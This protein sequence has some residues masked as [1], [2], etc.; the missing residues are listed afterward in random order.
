MFKDGGN[1][2]VLTFKMHGREG[3][4]LEIAQTLEGIVKKLK[5]V[6]GCTGAEIYRDFSEES[7]FFL[8]EEWQ[9]RSAMEE[10]TNS[11]L[12]AALLGIRSLLEKPPEVK[13]YSED[14]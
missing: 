1:M 14:L 11:G 6:D 7:S 5:K 3:S 10:H 4:Q 2:Y 12:F 8:V 9:K 13:R